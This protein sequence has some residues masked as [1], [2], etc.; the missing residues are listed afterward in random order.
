MAIYD[1]LEDIFNAVPGSGWIKDVAESGAGWIGDF[2]KTPLGF[3]TLSVITNNLYGPIART[4][5]GGVSGM[6]TV[7]PQIAS[8]VW[9]VPGMA[10]GEAFTDAYIKEFINR[11]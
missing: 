3:F 4:S 2:A 6:Q 1:F 11:V 5:L 10:A 9:A 8:V 7:G